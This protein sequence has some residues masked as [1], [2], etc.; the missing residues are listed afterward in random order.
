MLNC[1][2]YKKCSLHNYI[3]LQTNEPILWADTEGDG[4]RPPP[5]EKTTKLFDSLAILVRIPGNYK[6]TKPAFNEGPASARQRNTN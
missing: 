5:P 6:A 3:K 1:H 2:D 4:V